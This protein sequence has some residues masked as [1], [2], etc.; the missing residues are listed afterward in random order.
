MIIIKNIEADELK[1]YLSKNR[2]LTTHL[3]CFKLKKITLLANKTS[4]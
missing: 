1:I 4:H 2:T 3:T